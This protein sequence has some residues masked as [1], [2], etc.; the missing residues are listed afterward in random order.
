MMDQPALFDLDQLA[1]EIVA[2]TA[3]QRPGVP[4]RTHRQSHGTRHVPGRSPLGGY[5]L[6]VID[7]K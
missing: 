2:A 7:G 6:A 5:D 1:R 4:V 3:W